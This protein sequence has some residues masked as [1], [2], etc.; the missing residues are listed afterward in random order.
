MI[1][2]CELPCGA[3]HETETC[4]CLLLC[5]CLPN[6]DLHLNRNFTEISFAC[7]DHSLLENHSSFP[8]HLLRNFKDNFVMHR[9]NDPSSHTQQS[10]WK[11][12]KCFFRYVCGCPLNR[13]VVECILQLPNTGL[14]D[15]SLSC[16]ICKEFS[17][18]GFRNAV[19]V[20]QANI[21]FQYAVWMLSAEVDSIISEITVQWHF[22][23]AF[24]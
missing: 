22:G 6:R 11:Q 9:S 4:F 17:F 2:K 23:P 13:R 21:Q 24:I 10:L 3:N 18:A 16:S 5:P 12:T 15:P 8:C 14:I 20:F 7:L 1:L 19:E